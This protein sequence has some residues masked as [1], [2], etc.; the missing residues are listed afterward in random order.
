MGTIQRGSSSIK[1]GTPTPNP[2]A[3][4]LPP[5]PA[6]PKIKVPPETVVK[7]AGGTDVDPGPPG[8]EGKRNDATSQPVMSP[9][10]SPRRVLDQYFTDVVALGHGDSY[11][12]SGILV[13]SQVVLTARH[14]IPVSQVVLGVSTESP[15]AVL[16]V[17]RTIE[18]DDAYS[19]AVRSGRAD[20]ESTSNATRLAVRAALNGS[21]MPWG[22]RQRWRGLRAVLI[23]LA[24]CAGGSMP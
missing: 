10:I 24:L 12:C 2:G 16:T 7:V 20:A 17:Q 18:S 3:Q 8:N 11:H 9:K 19:Y 5:S 21:D 22:A 4:T 1:Y 15:D 23:R 14:C 13:A 6:P